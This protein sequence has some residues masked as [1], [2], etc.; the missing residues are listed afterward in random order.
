MTAKK[1]CMHGIKHSSIVSRIRTIED[2]FIHKNGN[3]KKYRHSLGR[4]RLLYNT[5]LELF[6]IS[7]LEGKRHTQKKAHGNKKNKTKDH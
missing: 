5:E 3:R 4:Q 6:E 7:I 1:V 2:G